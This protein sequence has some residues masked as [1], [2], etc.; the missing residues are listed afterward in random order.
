MSNGPS[1]KHFSRTP[2]LEATA[3]TIQG[4]ARIA[5][6]AVSAVAAQ[7]AALDGGIYDIWCDVNVWLK[8]DTV[9]N[10]VTTST[11]Y[12][13]RANT[14][15]PFAVSDGEKIGAIAGAAGTLSAHRVN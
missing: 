8:I 4:N 6:L 12:L 13:L 7:T 15:V 3:V 11:G 9:A 2:N 10:D 1:A 14:T 5:D